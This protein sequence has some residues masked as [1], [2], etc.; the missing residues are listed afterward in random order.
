MKKIVLAL[1]AVPFLTIP[2]FA[3]SSAAVDKPIVVAQGVDVRIGNTGVRVGERNRH[4]DRDVR[5]HHRDR[6][7]I[8]VKRGHRHHDRDRDRDRR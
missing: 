3:G 5:R 6:A 1:I 8:V 2:V 4:R 7:P